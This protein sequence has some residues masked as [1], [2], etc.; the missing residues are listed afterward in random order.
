MSRGKLREGREKY[1]ERGVCL[2]ARS[3]GSLDYLDE[4][5]FSPGDYLV[6]LVCLVYSVC[7]V[8]MVYFVTIVESV[9]NVMIVREIMK[10]PGASFAEIQNCRFQIQNLVC[11]IVMIVGIVNNVM[12]V[13][14]EG[15][16]SNYAC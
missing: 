3:Q 9:N 16:L 5:I 7:S 1:K 12:I 10:P 8:Y 6:Y 11:S 4:D 13:R 15:S 14:I 2:T